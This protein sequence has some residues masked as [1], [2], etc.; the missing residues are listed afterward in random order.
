MQG[1]TVLDVGGGVG[2]LSLEL[3]ERGAARAT[4]VEMS[5]GYEEAAAELLAE[6]R[7]GGRVE[8]RIGDFVAD[9]GLVEPHDVVL[10]HRV[11]CC[12]PD[13]DR[14]VSMAAAHAH[15]SL[16]LT[17]PRERRLTRIGFRGMNLWLAATRCGF[18]TFVHPFAVVDAAARREGLTLA[19][20]E[21]QGAIWENA[22]WLRNGA[23]GNAAAM[24]PRHQDL[25]AEEEHAQ[26]EADVE[27]TEDDLGPDEDDTGYDEELEDDE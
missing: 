9:A 2:N 18:R 17:Y 19:R 3:L 25:A 24:E 15:R 14:L 4:V 13:A 10:L 7:I 27:P 5:D 16:A 26:R 21:T 1:D 12:Y 20:R 8:R 6:H 22:V 23:D 11:I